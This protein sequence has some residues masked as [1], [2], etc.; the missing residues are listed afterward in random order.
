MPYQIFKLPKETLIAGAAIKPSWKVNFYVTGTTTPTPVYT[1]S[2]LSTTHT[3]PVQADSGGTLATVYLDPAVTYKASVYDQNDVLQYTVDPVNDSV[4]SQAIIGGLLYPRTAA[5][6]SAGVTPTNYAYPP[7]DVRRY[8]ADPTGA[9]DST[10][11][12]QNACDQAVQIG[13]I[14]PY[15]LGGTFLLDGSQK[16]A[17][18]TSCDF[19]AATFN[20]DNAPAIGIEVSTG[21]AANPTDYLWNVDVHLP[22]VVNLDKPAT[23]W[24][25]QGTGVRIV[26]VQNSRI[27]CKRITGFNVGLYLDAYSQGCAYNE[28][29]IEN[30]YNN[31]INI[32][33]APGNTTGYVNE[34][35]FIGGACAH[36]SGEGTNITS[37]RHVLLQ[38]F[39]SGNVVN[40]NR[41]YGIS[42]EG[43]GPEYH[44]EDQGIYNHF[45]MCRWEA[46]APKVYYNATAMGGA[47]EGSTIEGGYGLTAIATTLAGVVAVKV[48]GIARRNGQCFADQGFS[49]SNVSGDTNRIVTIYPSSATEPWEKS[50]TATDWLWQWNGREF[51]GKQEGDAEASFR[52]KLDALNGRV[53]ING[54]IYWSSGSG[55]PE[56]VVTAPIGSM[57]SNTSGGASTTLYVKTSGSGNTGWTAK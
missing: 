50:A 41:F 35:V 34:N 25:A 31:K 32:C 44:V 47:I 21:S 43:D 24:A 27:Y 53:Y 29:H 11:A 6:I 7:G 22:T 14:P 40:N 1:T 18:K 26:N 16:L 54:G 49:W 15:A 2:A 51:V 8:G 57:Y 5:E 52:V 46:T 45:H 3:Q 4:L 12:I 30:Q 28:I 48:G 42:L 56:G 20:I 23:G 37:V 39:A 10:T 38:H 13:G 33:C 9:S 19:S 55:S 36:I 17:I